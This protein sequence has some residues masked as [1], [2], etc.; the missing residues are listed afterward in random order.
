MNAI[1]ND[2]LSSLGISQAGQKEKHAAAVAADKKDKLGQADFL[3]MMTEQL[4]NQNP[5]NPMDNGAF[6]A[7][8]AQFSTVQGLGDLN[9]KADQFIGSMDSDK[10]LRGAALIGHKV[11]VPGSTLSL[12]ADGEVS[13]TA[14]ATAKGPVSILIQDANGQQVRG[15]NLPDEGP[16]SRT[17]QWDGKDQAGNR[18]PQGSYTFIASQMGT[19]GKPFALDTFSDATVESVSLAKDGAKLNLS[20]AQSVQLKDVLQISN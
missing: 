17:F 14:K 16:G 3:V 12:A 7:Q 9:K 8:L 6:L 19:D 11:S 1:S 4:K 2:T 10:A 15:L 20:G 18:L 5:L 13:G